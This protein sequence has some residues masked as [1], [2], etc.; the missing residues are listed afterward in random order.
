MGEALSS[1]T[2]ELATLVFMTSKPPRRAGYF[3]SIWLL[4]L[5][6][7]FSL[8]TA[9]SEDDDGMAPPH[10]NGGRSGGEGGGTS[11][12]GDS[13]AGSHSGGSE[14]LGGEG[15]GASVGGSLPLPTCDDQP[16]TTGTCSE[17]STGP[18]CTCPSGFGGPECDDVNECSLAEPA[19]PGAACVNGFGYH[20]CGCGASEVLDGEV[21]QDL[22]ECEFSPCSTDADCT[23]LTNGYT[24]ACKAGFF[25]DGF[26]CVATD[27]PCA[28]DPCGAGATCVATS[29]GA[30]C[31]CP[32]GKSGRDNCDTTCDSLT[33]VDGPL[34]A[35]IE[36]TV[37]KYLSEIDPAVDLATRTSLDVSGS[38]VASLDGLECWPALESLNL[39]NT[40]LGTGDDDTPLAALSQLTR[41]KVVD[42]G[43]VDAPDLSALSGLPALESLYVGVGDTCPR[44][45]LGPATGLD[46]LAM[47]TRLRALDVSG[48]PIGD[49]TVLSGLGALTQLVA[50]DAGLTSIS[51]LSDL[52]LLRSVVLNDNEIEDASSL[53]SLTLLT[54]VSLANNPISDA[55]WVPDLP[56]LVSLDVSN[57]GL[58]SFPNLAAQGQLRRLNASQN[59]LSSLESFAA[60]SG[61]ISVILS[62]NEINS[63]APLSE[64]RH[65][66]DYLVNDNPLDCDAEA[67]RIAALQVG[68]LHIATDCEPEAE[69]P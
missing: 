49:G 61:L 12:G 13:L 17:E 35:K 19:C 25:G 37:G 2:G 38:S 28:T 62:D 22:D 58:E 33:I 36:A 40:A 53:T 54:D 30:V 57:T 68:G 29:A 1:K 60:S 11:S 46:G 52:K 3:R 48:Q 39:S 6:L 31:Q 65:V 27:D 10:S 69:A 51:A 34:R 47:L 56:L 55:D 67:S 42:L 23:N 26:D 14:G 16:C 5:P 20:Y 63:L 59:N 64:Q 43:C 18:V 21:C 7:A 24:C 8:G 45:G 50:A 15:G 66:G 41:L 32:S 4:S 44:A 9:C